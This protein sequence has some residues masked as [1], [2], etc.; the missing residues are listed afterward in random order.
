MQQ[1][2]KHA[3]PLAR[4]AEAG[5]SAGAEQQRSSQSS[6]NA[7]N[8]PGMMVADQ[9][10]A[11]VPQIGESARPLRSVSAP[12]VPAV[13]PDQ[14]SRRGRL[15]AGRVIQTR[16]DFSPGFLTLQSPSTL[17]SLHSSSPSSSSSY[18]VPLSSTTVVTAASVDSATTS[19]AL[20]PRSD[21]SQQQQQK[22]HAQQHEQHQHKDKHQ[23]S[24]PSKV[25]A[26]LPSPSLSPVSRV[27]ST[28]MQAQEHVDSESAQI[29]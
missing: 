24:S 10:I 23:P 5:Y 22:Q 15:V 3:S 12:T 1:Q 19:V 13:A 2:L 6:L 8:K 25:R 27:S 20:T 29:R 16:S 17:I 21:P 9:Q 11:S 18:C 14:S 28:A 26:R 4:N 7:K